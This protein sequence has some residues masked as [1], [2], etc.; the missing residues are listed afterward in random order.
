MLM[1][2]RMESDL[3]SL[4]ILR[5]KHARLLGS[6]FVCL[7]VFISNEF[8]AHGCKNNTVKNKVSEIFI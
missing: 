2:T 5:L 6:L 3:N 4:L 8:V 1:C 7:F